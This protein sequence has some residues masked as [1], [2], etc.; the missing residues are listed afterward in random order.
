MH[1]ACGGFAGLQCAGSQ[2]C[3][4][5]PTDDCDP[6]AGGADCIGYCIDVSDGG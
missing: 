4:D 6:D 5:D 2:A 1:A 3:V